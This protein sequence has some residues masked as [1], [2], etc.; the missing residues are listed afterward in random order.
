MV[1]VSDEEVHREGG[2]RTTTSSYECPQPGRERYKNVDRCV[3]AKGVIDESK[4][5]KWYRPNEPFLRVRWLRVMFRIF[6]LVLCPFYS[7]LSQ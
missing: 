5:A 3:Y 6:L 2:C 1:D 7:F 4:M